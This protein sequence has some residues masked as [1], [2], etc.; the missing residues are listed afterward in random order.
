MSNVRTGAS[1][2][3]NGIRMGGGAQDSKVRTGLLSWL[4]F[5]TILQSILMCLR[6]HT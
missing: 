2:D 1:N 5:N 3:F 4:P 6:R